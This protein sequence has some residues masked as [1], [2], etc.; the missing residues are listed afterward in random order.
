VS[1]LFYFINVIVS[2]IIIIIVKHKWTR[3]G[4]VY[5]MSDERTW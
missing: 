2:I 1:V 4:I 5:N 3:K